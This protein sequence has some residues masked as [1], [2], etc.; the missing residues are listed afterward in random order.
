MLKNTIEGVWKAYVLLSDQV[1]LSLERKDLEAARLL[2]D[3]RDAVCFAQDE[4]L[5]LDAVRRHK[6]GD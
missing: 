1:T 5:A 3:A 4:L 6:K 2:M